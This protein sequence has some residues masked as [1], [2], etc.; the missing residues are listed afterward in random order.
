[1]IQVRAALVCGNTKQSKRKGSIFF[2]RESSAFKNSPN[3]FRNKKQLFIP[4]STNAP[5]IG[6]ILHVLH[7]FRVVLLYDFR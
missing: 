5:C 6:H 4:K 1:M 3:A 7:V 2:I